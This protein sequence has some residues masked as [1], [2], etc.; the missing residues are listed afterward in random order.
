MH[1]S[2][3]GSSQSLL[4]ERDMHRRPFLS[5]KRFVTK[6]LLCT[7][8]K[9]AAAIFLLLGLWQHWELSNLA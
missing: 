2:Y 5:G 1:E 4:P 7:L 9:I 3:L 6:I 8:H